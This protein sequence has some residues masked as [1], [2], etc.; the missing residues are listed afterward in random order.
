M[1]RTI[2]KTKN[3]CYLESDKLKSLARKILLLLKYLTQ[4]IE[5][6]V[7]AIKGSIITIEIYRLR[8]YIFGGLGRLGRILNFIKCQLNVK[9]L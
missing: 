6:T 1:L 2:I 8:N 5:L 4:K 3:H 7:K 9:F